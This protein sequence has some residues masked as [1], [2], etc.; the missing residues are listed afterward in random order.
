[1]WILTYGRNERVE[2]VGMALA[3]ASGVVEMM[4]LGVH[5]CADRA[6][7][8]SAAQIQSQVFG[9]LWGKRTS[10][11]ADLVFRKCPANT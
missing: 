1:V 4:A 9:S 10:A 11:I 5:G 2:A 3:L 7:V 8:K 6:C